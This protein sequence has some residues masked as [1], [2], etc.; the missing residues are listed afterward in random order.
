MQPNCFQVVATKV[1]L[2][3]I[4]FG[5]WDLLLLF[6]YMGLSNGKTV[7]QIKED[8]KRDFIPALI[9]EGSIWPILQVANFRF[10]PVRNQR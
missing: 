3:G 8:V 6:T 7:P 4:I 10:V 5:P 9:M 2:D 1:A